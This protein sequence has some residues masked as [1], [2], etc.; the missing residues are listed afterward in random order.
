[1]KQVNKLYLITHNELPQAAQAVQTSHALAEFA[2]E[3][4]VLFKEWSKHKTLV[5]LSVSSKEELQ[6]LNRKLEQ[7]D[8][9]CSFFVE[10]DIGNQ[11]T[12]TATIYH[13]SLASLPLAFKG[14]KKGKHP[15]VFHYNKKHNTD[16]SIP[17]WVV[18]YKGKSHYVKHLVSD[19]GFSTKETPNN[20]HTKG[21]L[22][23]KGN[24]R[25]ENEVAY[26]T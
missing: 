14:K 4:P 11:L 19:N 15:I 24:L 18:K 21:S 6:K 26:I 23:F 22:K 9:P 5:V 3:H 17:P 16:Q 2:V 25:I 10:P 20:E 13:P 7:D 8:H 1:M 12:A